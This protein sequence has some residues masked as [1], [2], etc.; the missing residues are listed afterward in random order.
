LS[1]SKQIFN[2]IREKQI[3]SVVVDDIPSHIVENLKFKEKQ[4][5]KKPSEKN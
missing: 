2:S 1:K 4:L 5:K 3:N